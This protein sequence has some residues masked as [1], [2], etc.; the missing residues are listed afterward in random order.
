MIILGIDPGT[1]RMGW[2][3]IE[4]RNWKL[5]IGNSQKIYLLGYGCVVTGKED[6]VGKRLGILRKELKKVINS[7]NPDIMVIE[8]LFFGMN[9]KTAISV[10]QAT[11]IIHLTASESSIPTVEY[12]G[13][14]VKLTVAGHGRADKKVLQ[15][16]VRR[17]LGINN[18]SFKGK[19]KGWDDASDALAIAICHVHKT[20]YDKNH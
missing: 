1:A 18:L 10:G 11:G 15:T 7:H 9:A 17:F 2:G 13:L 20:L 14:Q 8:R 6:G 4:I 19:K 12:T 3:V 16:N 5:E